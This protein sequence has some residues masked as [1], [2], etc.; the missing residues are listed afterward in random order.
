MWDIQHMVSHVHSFMVV[1]RPGAEQR[2]VEA[3][4]CW[5]TIWEETS[6]CGRHQYS[7]YP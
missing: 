7:G 1:V 5:S 3:C 4:D 6:V 2:R